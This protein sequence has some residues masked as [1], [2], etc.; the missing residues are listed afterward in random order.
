VNRAATNAAAYDAEPAPPA[1]GE[2]VGLLAEFTSPEE[3]LAAAR[4]VRTA[5]YTRWDAHSPFP[6]HGLDGA[7]GLRPTRLPW[8]VMLCG[9]AGA[10]GGLL[11]QWWTNAVN[12]PFHVSGKPFFSLPAN[13]PVMFE[14]TVLLAAI[15]AV[16]GMLALNGLP[17]L[18][19]AFFSRPKFRRVTTDRFFISIEAGDPK[20][21]EAR[22]R[23]FLDSLGS[24]AL[25]SVHSA[26][27]ARPP[28]WMFRAAVVIGV[29]LLVPPALIARARV[30]KSPNP[31]IHL[32]QDMDNQE[33]FK[34]QRADPLF[35]DGRAMRPPVL[36][37]IARGDYRPDD[38]LEH[39]YHLIGTSEDGAPR[40][41]YEGTFPPSLTLD[42]AFVRRGQQ[43]FEIYCAPC[44]GLDG[45]GQGIVSL[46]AVAREQATWVQPTSLQDPLVRDRPVGHLFNTITKG[47]RT[48]PAYGDQIAVQD[49]WAIVAYLRALQRSTQARIEDVPES[50]RSELR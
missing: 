31:P 20:F 42:E 5:G 12:Y 30:S 13:I 10:A 21:D 29:L 8:I 7:M 6:V 25:E 48:M 3:L 34:T 45:S 16:F 24:A 15:G 17:L 33:K 2:L 28:A 32:V 37:T 43:R 47:I 40:V 9:L 39:G 46:R 11:L 22:T 38:H 18:H 27:A 41:E 44:H 49:R 35:A 36:G 19:N 14:T 50:L 26:P 1:G 23:Q 4:E